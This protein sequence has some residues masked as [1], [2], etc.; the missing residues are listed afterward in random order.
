[1]EVSI[2]P[3]ENGWSVE[4]VCLNGES[5]KAE[6]IGTDAK[7]RATEYLEWKY[8]DLVFDDE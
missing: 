1:M 8:A 6:F 3:T 2:G 7:S 4:E 5:H